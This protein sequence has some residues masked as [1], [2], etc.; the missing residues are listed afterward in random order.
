LKYSSRTI[1]IFT[2]ILENEHLLELNSIYI[3][4]SLVCIL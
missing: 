3:F 2:D 1:C 4:H